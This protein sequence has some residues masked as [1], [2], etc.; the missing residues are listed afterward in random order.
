[1]SSGNYP[2]SSCKIRH[3]SQGTERYIQYCLLTMMHAPELGQVSGVLNC[4]EQQLGELAKYLTISVFQVSPFPIFSC[5]PWFPSKFASQALLQPTG[6]PVLSKG[7]LSSAGPMLLD[8]RLLT[9]HKHIAE[10]N[11]DPDLQGNQRQG[12]LCRWWFLQEGYIHP[13]TKL[14][15]NKV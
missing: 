14:K 8:Q 4:P 13:P 6:K 7:P 3:L 5:L 11:W 15:N 10:Y 2:W 9:L 12:T 1:M